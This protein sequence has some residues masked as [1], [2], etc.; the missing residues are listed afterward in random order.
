MTDR[1]H[2]IFAKA[3]EADVKAILEHLKRASV[4]TDY[5][6]QYSDELVTM[7]KTQIE[8][9]LSHIHDP[10]A[11]FLIVKDCESVVGFVMLIK[12]YPFYRASHRA[13]LGISLEK[14]YWNRGIGTALIRECFA[15]ARSRGIEMIEL[16]VHAVNER[17]IAVYQKQ[18]FREIYRISR[19]LKNR[20]GSYYDFIRM[21]CENF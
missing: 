7:E 15:F 18:G 19:A 13:V 21:R 20:D 4:E 5:L 6:I 17:A 8:L 12:E 11:L 1:E 2:C 14:A 9:T 3:E 10:Q 16:D